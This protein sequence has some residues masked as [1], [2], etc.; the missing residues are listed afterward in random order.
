MLI[1]V[2]GL[3][4]AAPPAAAHDQIVSSSPEAGGTVSEV[5]EQISLT[6]SGEI[7]A[8]FSAVIVEV[9]AADGQN[10]ATGDPTVDGTT[11]TQ[12]VQPGQVGVFTVRWRVVSSD[13]HPISNEYQYTV[14]AVAVPP[15][16]PT[17]DVT[18]E[19][20]PRPSP[21]ATATATPA[22]DVHNGPSGGGEI[23]PG[24]AV[25]GVVVVLGGGLIIVLM[26]ARERRRRDREVAAES[27]KNTATGKDEPADES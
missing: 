1:A 13:G 2:G 3:F 24:L 7:F 11:V 23:F 25:L 8:D 27:G 14:E 20:T 18:E 5:P 17:P 9:I 21:T 6:F 4:A 10:I 15:S 19:P 12:A 22:G 26:V 16:T